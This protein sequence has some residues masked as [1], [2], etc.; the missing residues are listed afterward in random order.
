MT[1]GES[2]LSDW[3]DRMDRQ[4]DRQERWNQRLYQLHLLLKQSV[5]GHCNEERGKVEWHCLCTKTN[6]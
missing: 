4:D 6:D 3:I 5:R 1:Y 2:A